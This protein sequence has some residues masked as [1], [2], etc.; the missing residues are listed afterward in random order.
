MESWAGSEA[1]C[2]GQHLSPRWVLE[3]VGTR[4]NIKGRLCS[5]GRYGRWG[6]R[7][8]LG[9]T[10]RYG[11]AKEELT[12]WTLVAN[13][14]R[15]DLQHGNE[16]IYSSTCMYMTSNSLRIAFICPLI[17][18]KHVWWMAFVLSVTGIPA[19]CTQNESLNSFLECYCSCSHQL[20]FM[21]SFAVEWECIENSIHF[22][23]C[24]TTVFTSLLMWEKTQICLNS[25][26]SL[27]PN[28]LTSTSNTSGW[29]AFLH[30]NS[31]YHGT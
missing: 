26:N 11:T 13:N 29:A 2:T 27:N 24:F 8:G 12:P 21:G 25:L 15:A 19:T 20:G 14:S 5:H 1:H 17:L 30:V 4:S 23:T 6:E 9:F 16:E 18:A 3:R 7:S 22:N 31:R 28:P 10:N